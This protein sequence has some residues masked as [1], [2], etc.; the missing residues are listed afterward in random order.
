M[1]IVEIMRAP[2]Q[3]N[4]RGHSPVVIGKPLHGADKHISFLYLKGMTRDMVLFVAMPPSAYRAISLKV[5]IMTGGLPIGNRLQE[6]QNP[7]YSG[8]TMPFFRI[9]LPYCR[10]SPVWTMA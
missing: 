2:F 9:R 5:R 10:V 8:R 1:V 6:I 3:N 4:R 7:G